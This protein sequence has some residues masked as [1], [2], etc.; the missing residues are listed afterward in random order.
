MITA[1]LLA[2]LGFFLFWQ[3]RDD[4]TER[5]AG[6]SFTTSTWKV[7]ITGIMSPLIFAETQHLWQAALALSI[8][9]FVLTAPHNLTLS[10]PGAYPLPKPRDP[11]QKALFFLFDAV[12]GDAL[13]Q[14]IYWAASIARYAL[15]VSLK[16]VAMQSEVMILA[17]PVA[18]LIYYP[19]VH[20][21]RS[22]YVRAGALGALLFGVMGWELS[23]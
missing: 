17:G 6:L 18:S 3:C 13:T 1:L 19:W 8:F 22:K 15:P 23:Q 9:V 7:I 4:E 21:E 5:L 11:I 12:P 10:P 14:P 16:G 2:A 20:S